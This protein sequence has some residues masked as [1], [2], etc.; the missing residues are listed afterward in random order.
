M[1][2]KCAQPPAEAFIPEHV[3]EQVLHVTIDQMVEC[4]SLKNHIGSAVAGALGGF[5]AHAANVVAAIFAA[6]GQDLAQVVESAECLTVME[7][8]VRPSSKQRFPMALSAS[9]SMSSLA[10]CGRPCE[11][12]HMANTNEA[13]PNEN[14]SNDGSSAPAPDEEE[15]T[16]H[17][18]YI[19]VTLPC[20][21]VGTVGGG[22]HLPAQ[23]R[24]VRML[25]GA[26][27]T[28]KLLPGQSADRLAESIAGAV[29]AGELSL[30]AALA[31]GHL[32]DA[33]MRL[34]RGKRAA[35]DQHS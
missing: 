18:L 3:V 9:S 34:N 8:V 19:S 1:H 14:E 30:M 27:E 12:N 23:S 5:N 4:N 22:T 33:H 35:S 24:C 7:K 2:V 11:F 21:E 17:A 28:E 16:L 31:A 29:L 25:Q 26:T 10:E 6:T 13:A 32:V 15:E 20:M